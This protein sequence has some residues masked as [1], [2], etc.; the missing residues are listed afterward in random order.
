MVKIHSFFEY[1]FDRLFVKSFDF[2]HSWFLKSNS[3]FDSL[4][5]N[6]SVYLDSWFFLKIFLNIF[7][8]D[9]KNRCAL[10]CA[11]SYYGKSEQ[12]LVH[13]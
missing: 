3:I 6:S 12:A 10:L 4:L 8:I 7:I 13:Y 11:F 9:G 2:F 1:F 5:L